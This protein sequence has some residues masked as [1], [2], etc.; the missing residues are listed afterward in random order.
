MKI[1]VIDNDKEQCDRIKDYLQRP[2][3]SHNVFIETDGDKTVELIELHKPSIVLLDVDLGKGKTNGISICKELCELPEHRNGT[4]GIILISGKYKKKL[5]QVQGLEK[6]ADRYILKP[7][8]RSVLASKIASLGRRIE[9]K[10][11]RV[12]H[13][14]DYLIIDIERRTVLFNGEPIELNASEF[15]ILQHLAINQDIPITRSALITLVFRN[16]EI[17]DDVINRHVCN[18]RKK[19]QKVEDQIAE[20]EHMPSCEYIETLHRVGYKLL[21]IPKVVSPIE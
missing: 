4:L 11:E 14:G 12:I 6:G 7:F 2:K 16:M 1:L 18:I 13:V 20:K 8:K 15:D 21:S 9:I 17:A 5:N 10:K 3:Y 19:F